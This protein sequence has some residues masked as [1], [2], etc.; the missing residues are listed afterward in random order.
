MFLALKNNWSISIPRINEICSILLNGAKFQ[1]LHLL[2]KLALTESG[3][4]CG[5]TLKWSASIQIDKMF[6]RIN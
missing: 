4:H 3:M 1:F 6:L 2:M 5:H